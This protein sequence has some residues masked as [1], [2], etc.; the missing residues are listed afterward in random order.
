MIA[1]FHIVLSLSFVNYYMNSLKDKL[2]KEDYR[3]FIKQVECVWRYSLS[4]LKAILDRKTCESI[5]QA[6]LEACGYY[7]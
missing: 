7:I 3:N 1:E 4:T 5:E 6:C 2:I